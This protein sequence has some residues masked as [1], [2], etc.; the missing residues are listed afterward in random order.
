MKRI[1]IAACSFALVLAGGSAMAQTPSPTARS[2]APDSTAA[3]ASYNP[4]LR[5]LQ[6]ARNTLAAL[7]EESMTQDA[8]DTLAQV[9]SDF[10]ALYKAYTG[11]A[12]DERKG[13]ESVAVGH[14]PD[15]SWKA[16]YAAAKSGIDALI[17]PNAVGT[18]G[19]SAG[20][21]AVGTSGTTSPAHASGTS[22]QY[23]LRKDV[24]DDLMQLRQQL[25][26]FNTAAAGNAPP[27]V[28][29]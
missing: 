27:D 7:T 9:N 20:N 3:A 29:K 16:D 18:S 12:P 17:G 10:R 28:S 2:I 19:S 23:D 6:A 5:S 15:P 24:R 25:A 13:T 8:R 11:T 14:T 26:S 4:A 21:A 22:R 1:V